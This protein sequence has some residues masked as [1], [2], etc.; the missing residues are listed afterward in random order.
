MAI[1]TLTPPEQQEQGKLGRRGKPVVHLGVDTRAKAWRVLDVATG[2]VHVTRNLEFREGEMYKDWVQAGGRL[3]WGSARL[4]RSSSCYLSSQ[5][6]P[7]SHSRASA[8]LRWSRMLPWKKTRRRQRPHFRAFSSKGE[9]LGRGEEE[10][11]VR[12]RGSL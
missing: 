11:Q 7:H 3:V 8:S 5:T 2:R 6:Y 12:G 10:C 1:A 4:R 9:V